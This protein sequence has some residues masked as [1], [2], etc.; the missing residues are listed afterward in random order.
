MK[1]LYCTVS[2]HCVTTRL[3]AAEVLL[4]L[5]M[6]CKGVKITA[7]GAFYCDT[8]ERTVKVAKQILTST[9]CFLER[10]GNE[11]YIWLVK[12]ILRDPIPIKWAFNEREV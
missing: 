1:E 8:E 5:P 2:S 7:K 12:I 10:D 4:M 9:R 6:P 11:V 3:D